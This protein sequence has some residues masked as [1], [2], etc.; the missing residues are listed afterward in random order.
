MARKTISDKDLRIIEV[1]DAYALED[2][3][4]RGEAASFI[5]QAMQA[6]LGPINATQEAK[7]TFGADPKWPQIVAFVQGVTWACQE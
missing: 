4:V 3:S 1:L 5:V 7:K 6:G 2:S